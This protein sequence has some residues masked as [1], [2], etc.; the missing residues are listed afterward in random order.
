M[1]KTIRLML[2]CL[3]TSIAVCSCQKGSYWDFK[4]PKNVLCKGTWWSSEC[5]LDGEWIDIS[6]PQFIDVQFS[7]KFYTDGTYYGTGAFGNGKGTYDAHG[8]TI[9]TYV[10]GR[11]YFTYT[12]HSLNNDVAEITMFTKS[13][14]SLQFRVKN[15]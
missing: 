13:G 4:Y 5:F 10:N 9:R 3:L 7:I 14:Q 11:L 6:R 2:L 1:K 8:N 12:V 15:I